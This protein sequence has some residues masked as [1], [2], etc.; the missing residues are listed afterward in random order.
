VTS[1]GHAEPPTGIGYTWRCGS[2]YHRLA[3]LA[4]PPW[5]G[6]F[7]VTPIAASAKRIL[8]IHKVTGV[9]GSERHL[10][11]LLPGLSRLRFVVSLLLLT[12]PDG[13]MDEY[14]AFFRDQGI[15]TEATVIRRDLDPM[16]LIDVYQR[17]RR[18][19]VDLVHTH[20]IHADLY[21]GLAARLAGVRPI[22]STRHNDDS[23]RRRSSMRVLTRWSSRSS[24]RVVTPSRYLADFT[25]RMEGVA[26]EKIRTIPYAV[27]D[28]ARVGGDGIR[29]EIGI[30]P[31]APLV[32]T[33]GRLI[34]QKGHRYLLQAW[35]RV[36][37]ARPDARLLIV[38][39]GPWRSRLAAEARGLGVEGTVTFTGWRR[40]VSAILAAATVCVHPSLWEGFGLVLLEA[41]AAGVPVVASRVSSIPEIVLDGHTGYLVPPLDGTALAERILGLLADP[42]RCRQMGEAGRRRVLETFNAERM[43]RATEAVYDELLA[44]ATEPMVPRR[45]PD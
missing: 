39:E 32:V 38:G 25:R 40:D 29:R 15:R 30:E 33:V 34:E 2:L 36:T 43:V 17:I 8:H 6:G 3:G 12:V 31:D 18:G 20:L 24:A 27:E 21:G 19:A 22:V 35:P 13:P 41:M 37:A 42:A 26:P 5:K 4:P 44:P 16:C 28:T 1:A 14:A 7:E 23:F 9:G 11:I 45:T 10:Q